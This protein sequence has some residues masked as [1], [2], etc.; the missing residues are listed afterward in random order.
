M[1]YDLSYISD[2]LRCRIKPA[3]EVSHFHSEELN[4]RV[5]ENAYIA[6][7]V[8]WEE[9]I[10]CIMDSNGDIIPDSRCLEWKEDSRYYNSHPVHVVEREAIYLGFL[11]TGFGHSYT[12]DL[13]K[14]WFVN[15]KQFNDLILNGTEVVYTTSWNDPLPESTKEIIRYAGYDIS[16]AHHITE[17]TQYKK[18]YVPENCFKASPLGRLYSK[19]YITLINKIK[20]AI[21]LP[22]QRHLNKIYFSRS[23]FIRGLNKEYGEKQIE[24]VFSKLGYKII[25]PEELS[26]KEQINLVMHCRCFASTDGSVAHL[27]LFCKANTDVV[28]INKAVYCNSHQVTINEIA[29][30]NVT[31]IESHH[32]TKVDPLHPWWGP[33]YLYIT[34]FL[35]R[36]VGHRIF[37]IPYWMSPSYWKYTRNLLYRCYNRIRRFVKQVSLSN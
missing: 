9:S 34:K 4:L 8:G 30:L 15:S 26:I 36:Y 14:L 13:R 5:W 6:P 11:L 3:I 23:H 17:L 12:D 28:I 31:Y 18:I 35:E 27:S 19:E 22:D 37:H 16:K 1:K 24:H 32:S 20:D 10:G 2:D 29:D 21:I 25:Y 33:F 7:Y